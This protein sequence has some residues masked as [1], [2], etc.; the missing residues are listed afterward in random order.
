MGEEAGKGATD[1]WE[2][3]FPS[4]SMPSGKKWI[5]WWR[6]TQAIIDA[7]GETKSSKV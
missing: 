7:V 2:G 3:E 4:I 1:I 6:E 5:G